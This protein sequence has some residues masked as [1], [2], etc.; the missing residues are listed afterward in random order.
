MHAALAVSR[1][2]GVGKARQSG[3]VDAA[4][5]PVEVGGFRLHIR[6]RRECAWIFVA[7]IKPGPGEELRAAM[8]EARRHAKAVQFYFVQP[9][10]PRRR[11]RDRLAKLRRNES[12]K[13]RR[14]LALASTPVVG[15]EGL[16]AERS[17]TRDICN[18]TRRRNLAS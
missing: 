12:G 17:A 5:F 6:E 3:I 11:F 8:V 16:E 10:R 7:P 18:P 14:A 4:Q 2:L 13:G 15:L 9:P 1:R